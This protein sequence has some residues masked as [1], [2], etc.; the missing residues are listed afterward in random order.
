MTRTALPG[1][2]ID[3]IRDGVTSKALRDHGDYAVRRALL[4]TA[5]SAIQHGWSRVDWSAEVQERRS[6]LGQQVMVD[7]R[8]LLRPPRTVQRI[9]DSAWKTAEE[10]VADHPPVTRDDVDARIRF[11]RDLVADPDVPI[12]DNDRAVIS[13]GC[14]IGDRLGTDRPALPRRAVSEATGLT[15]KAVRVS[16][17]RLHNSGLMPCEVRGMSGGSRAKVRRASCY[18]LPSEYSVSRQA[19]GTTYLPQERGLWAPAGSMW[20]P[21]PEG[22]QNPAAHY[23]GPCIDTSG[24]KPAPAVAVPL[25]AMTPEMLAPLVDS[26]FV[27]RLQALVAQEERPV[28]SNVIPLQRG[29]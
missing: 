3:L 13:H 1:K 5:A 17:G 20:A 25:D 19:W 7:N 15:D 21:A 11:A 12:P 23:V 2:T 16:L 4:S 29:A 10:W 24:P 14:D 8:G 26:A 18:R 6:N 27:A 22:T 9:L 28:P